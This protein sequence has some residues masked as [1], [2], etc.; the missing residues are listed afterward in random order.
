[1]KPPTPQKEVQKFIGVINYYHNMWTKRSHTLEPL[2]KLKSIKKKYKWTKAE[3]DAFEKTKQIMA[4][5]TLLIYPDFNETFKILTNAITFQLGAVIIQK[6]RSIDFY[7]RKL[8]D[9]KQQYTVTASKLLSVVET[10]K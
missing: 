10:L 8:T 4:R 1:M 9:D 5:S 6:Y 2:N 3:Q 7:S